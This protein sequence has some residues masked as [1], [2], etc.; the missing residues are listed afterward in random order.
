MMHGDISNYRSFIIGFRVEDSLLI[1]KEGIKNSLINLIKGKNHNAT[2][3]ERVLGIMRYIYERTSYTISLVVSAENYTKEM[4]DFLDN[5]HIPFNQ[6]GVLL[7]SE[8]EV[9]MMLNTGEL[10]YY[11]DTNEVRR[12]QINS[13]FAMDIDQF[14]KELGNMSTF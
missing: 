4:Q 11:V 10:S 13:R 2:L 12:C 9:T 3:D 8:S 5:M 6:V 1:Y 7:K 14:K